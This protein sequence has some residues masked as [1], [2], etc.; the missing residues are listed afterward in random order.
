MTA[1]GTQ[2]ECPLR[3]QLIDWFD[4]LVATNEAERIERHLDGCQRCRRA[5]LDWSEREASPDNPPAADCIDEETLVAYAT[6]APAAPPPAAAEIERHLQHCTRCVGALQHLMRLPQQVEAAA[7]PETEVRSVVAAPMAAGARAT[8][9]RWFER[10]RDL[11]TPGM[12]PRAAWAAAAVLVL[13]IGV[14]R[15][16]GSGVDYSQPRPRSAEQVALVEVTA[17]TAGHARPAADEPV[18][19]QLARGTRGRWLETAGTW[20]RIELADGRRVWLESKM[21]VNVPNEQ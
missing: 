5:L 2:A 18:V 15:F 8:A 13:A 21:V 1:I 17:D 19:L 10:V 12:W 4:G 16:V 11:F 6:A 14:S 3:S 9:L 20:T 7:R